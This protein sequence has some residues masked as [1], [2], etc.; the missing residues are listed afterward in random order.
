MVKLSS[1][2]SNVCIHRRG[3]SFVYHPHNRRGVSF[4]CWIFCSRGNFRKIAAIRNAF[5]SC[6]VFQKKQFL[7]F[8]FIS[9]WPIISSLDTFQFETEWRFFFLKLVINPEQLLRYS[10]NPSF[11]RACALVAVRPPPWYT[12]VVVMSP[13]I[14]SKTLVEST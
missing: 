11:T 3:D 5:R 12:G 7:F 1:Q 8:H 10:P 4:P 2:P 9:K 14:N 13:V 6:L